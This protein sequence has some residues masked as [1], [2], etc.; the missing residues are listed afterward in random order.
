MP[1]IKIE[2][3]A[4]AVLGVW[5][6]TE[7]EAFFLNQI[8]AGYMTGY[9]PQRFSERRRKEFLA[10]RWLLRQ[11][12]QDDSVSFSLDENGKLKDTN[13]NYQFSISHSGNRVAVIASKTH[14][15]GID[16]EEIHP[17]ILKV[18]HKFLNEDEKKALGENPE[19]WRIT[20][21][22]SAKESIFKMIETPGLSFSN[23]IQLQLPANE[24]GSFIANV[25]W[26]S[27][28]VQLNVHFEKSVG[29][30]LT[31]CEATPEG[32]ASLAKP[33]SQ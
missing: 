8:P 28:W 10:S 30:V 29:F 33:R 24:A 14:P 32:I 19:L 13:G 17:R 4:N 21:C 20:L 12:I 9:E 22:W 3:L 6:A 25:N 5:E 15:V 1:L 18:M 27:Q 31:Y 26:N 16:V 11:V 2:H 7:K 23:D